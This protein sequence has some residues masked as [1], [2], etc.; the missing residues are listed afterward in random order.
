MRKTAIITFLLL[1][2]SFITS[3]Q[4]RFLN[5]AKLVLGLDTSQALPQAVYDTLTELDLAGYQLTDISSVEN[6]KVLEY[7]YLS[8]NSI[9]D[10]SPLIKL[11]QL[12]YVNLRANKITDVSPF[13]L[14]Y[15][16]DL[17]V[18]IHE[19][20]VQDFAIVD[21]NY[22]NTVT[23]IGKEKQGAACNAP[24]PE[25][26]RLYHL[27]VF[28]KDLSKKEVY[29]MFR[30][31]SNVHSHATL[32]AGDG[33]QSQVKMTGYTDTLV[34]T[35]PN[36]NP[37]SA[38]LRL[39]DST[40]AVDVQ[41]ALGR[42]NL[43]RPEGRVSF[44][45]DSV[46]EFTWEAYFQSPLYEFQLRNS[47]SVIITLSTDTTTVKYRLDTAKTGQ[48]LH[49][50]VRAKRGFSYSAWSLAKTINLTSN[51]KPTDIR[52]PQ[53]TIAENQPAE[54]TVGLLSTT[55]PNSDDTHTYILESGVEYF[56]IENN[57]LKSKISFD[58]ETKADY[59]I[60]IKTTDA[61]GLAHSKNFTITI[62]DV[63]E[64]DKPT[65]LANPSFK[66]D[67]IILYPN[68]TTGQISFKGLDP[69]QSLKIEIFN[70]L[71]Q[72][73]KTY[74]QIQRYY[75][76]NDLPKGIYVA[77]LQSGTKTQIFTLT[78]N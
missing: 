62:S 32:A 2:L 56:K 24:A 7:L 23:F 57:I 40:R 61:G 9:A 74:N 5:T 63:K 58:Y 29:F 34:Y 8:N 30:G 78:L 49:W 25:F 50:M 45:A 46:L 11:Q 41:Y 48:I 22:F 35:Y 17:T 53:M 71:G 55:D 33:K 38:S 76:L 70:E 12:K 1:G 73:V 20:C 36:L 19:N 64:E 59:I 44:P 15:S 39:G 26:T 6:F 4:N 60:K 37:T 16:E 51:Q 43:L 66:L 68:P 75:D 10:V 72:V 47:D 52:L 18:V 21:E 14:T 42:V 77:V 28:P 65:A 54:T 27:D 3:A 67:A 31:R 13:I 69:T